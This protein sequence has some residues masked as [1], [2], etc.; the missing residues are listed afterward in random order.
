MCGEK[1]SDDELASC[2]A[3]AVICAVGSRVRPLPQRAAST[4]NTTLRADRNKTKS[5][6]NGSTPSEFCEHEENV[7]SVEVD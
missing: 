6:H 7:E 3:V 5:A 4:Q 2:G 1:E